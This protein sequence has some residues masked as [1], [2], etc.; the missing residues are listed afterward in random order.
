VAFPNVSDIIATTLENRSGDIADNVTGNNA[1]LTVM[2]EDG[3]VQPF[4]GGRLIYEELSFAENSN[5]QWYSGYDQLAT[6]AQ[7]VLS[8]A[9][10]ELK[11][12][13][14]A[15]TVSGRER[16]QNSGKEQIIDLVAS[17]VDVAE[18][19]IANL[20]SAALY[21]DGTGSGSKQLTGL[22]AAVPVD[23]TTGTYGG[24]NRANYTFWR[25]YAR[26]TNAAP[27][28]STIQ[29]IFNTAWANLVR[30]KDRPNLITTDDDVWSA[31]MASL[32]PLQRFTDSKLAQ[33]GFSTVKFMSADVVMDSGVGGDHTNVTAFFLNTKYLKFRPHKDCNMVPL[34]PDR[35][36]IN[37]DASV[38][39]L[40]WAG[41]L[42]CSNS[43]LQGQIVF[44]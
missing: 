33:L 3:K 13:A 16:L 27:S 11:Q 24:I 4:S 20:I 15:V 21:S 30:G 35:T 34:S 10:Y 17:R 8:A 29:G 28:S 18:S 12:A 19:S 5:T 6:G 39:I 26:D 44:S 41:N 36:A 42:T 25:S 2:K 31:Y 14:C 7:D 37:Q 1:L 9:E 38:K 40:A 22:L 23:P 43:L 32:Q